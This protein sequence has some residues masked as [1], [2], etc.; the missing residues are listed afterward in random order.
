MY[1]PQEPKEVRHQPTEQALARVL[2]K[3]LEKALQDS[4]EEVVRL[5]AMVAQAKALARLLEA[6]A[7][8]KVEQ[9]PRKDEWKNPPK[10]HPKGMGWRH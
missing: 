4:Q 1:F 3:D 6:K 10:E 7:L 2:V 5:Q 8:R 9:F